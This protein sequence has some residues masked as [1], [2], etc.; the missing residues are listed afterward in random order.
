MN[1]QKAVALVLAIGLVCALTTFAAAQPSQIPEGPIVAQA[2]PGMPYQLVDRANYISPF[3]SLFST[4]SGPSTSDELDAYYRSS[5]RSRLLDVP[6]MFGDRRVSGPTLVLTPTASGSP[7]LGT[8]IPVAAAISGLSVAENN[9]APPSDRVWV[10]YNYFH[11]ALDVQTD[12]RFGLTPQDSSQSLHRTVFA[13]EKLLDAGRTSI[14]LRMPFGGAFGAD[15]IAGSPAT[16]SL[17]GVQGH[18]VGN[19]NLILKRLLYAEEGFAL[20]AGLGL[21]VPTGSAGLVTYGPIQA[22]LDSQTVHFVPYL[23]M[24][25]RSGCWF[26]HMF[27]QIDFASQGDPLRVTLN[28]TGAS[29]LIGRVNQPALLGFDIGGGYWLVPPCGCNKGLALVG[30]LHYTTPLAED[31]QF[32]AVGTL[33]TASVNTAVSPAYEVLNFTAGLQVGLGC[34][35]QLRSGAVFP[36]RAEKVF[37]AEY[38]VQLNRGF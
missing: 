10:A 13:F 35:W 5:S 31:D 36:G 15:G 21:E 11:N 9:Q 18:N 4:T 19:M 38:L 32:S 20:S 12:G 1:K 37:D 17:Y 27:T 24:T 14:E 2:F 22:S 26:G 7:A 6:E 23:A 16:A 34:G 3:A 29:S 25:Q 28:D 8:E 30:E 33:T